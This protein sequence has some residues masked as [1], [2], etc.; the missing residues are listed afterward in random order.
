MGDAAHLNTM[1]T[2]LHDVHDI[3]RSDGT[4]QDYIY[5]H[6]RRPICNCGQCGKTTSL[7]CRRPEFNLFANGCP[8]QQRFRNVSCPEYYLFRGISVDDTIKCISARQRKVAAKS[9]NEE[10]LKKLSLLNVGD[11]NPSSIKSI[12][13]RTGKCESDIRAELS[14]KSS[15]VNNGFAGKKHRPEVLRNLAKKRAEQAKQ[16]SSPELIIWGMLHALRIDFEYQVPIDKYVVD[17]KVGDVLIEVYG[18]YW[19]G[20]KMSPSNKRRDKTKERF[21]ATE[22]QLIILSE[23]KII[24]NPL[25]TVEKLCELKR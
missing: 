22:H 3:R 19:H 12:I 17:F 10:H 15:G 13:A 16:I 8:H 14:K 11:S 2:H 6:F 1:M 5:E 9:A 18:D 21:L 20:V 24:N 4:F 23:S 25:S 7:H